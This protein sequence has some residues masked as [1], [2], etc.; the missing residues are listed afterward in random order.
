MRPRIEPLEAR[1]A[2]A[3][4][5]IDLRSFH[6]VE[7]PIERGGLSLGSWLSGAGDVNG[8]GFADLIM[9]SG[10]RAPDAASYVLFGKANGFGTGLHLSAL[11]G[12]DGFKIVGEPFFGGMVGSAGDVNG[13]GFADLL[14]SA[15]GADANNSGSGAS[16]VVFGK[17][18]SFGGVLISTNVSDHD[19][20]HKLISL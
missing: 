12:V 20:H 17:A 11:D 10:P 16:Y 15:S 3:A 14:I 2:P 13:D 4:A 9:G 6:G 8:D 7:F 18:T 19:G 5:S 1:I